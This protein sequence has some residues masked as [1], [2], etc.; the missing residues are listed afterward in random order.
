MTPVV[1]V[2]QESRK[3]RNYASARDY[4]T[5]RAVLPS[6]E[7][8][9]LDSESMI[10]RIRESLRDFT[11]NDYLIM[12]GDPIAIGVACTIA[13]CRVGGKIKVLKW[14]RMLNDNTGGYWPIE[15]DMCDILEE[16]T[17]VWRSAA[18]G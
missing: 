17:K 8:V 18:N 9:I 16:R 4:G 12:V 11:E 13:A 15:M 6:D 5:V 3:P 1:Y 2:V 7:Q 14:D 10:K